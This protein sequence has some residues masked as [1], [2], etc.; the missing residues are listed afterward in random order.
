MTT[1]PCICYF[2]AGVSVFGKKSVII[3]V[4]STIMHCE[5]HRRCEGGSE[6]LEDTE[7]TV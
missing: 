1:T 7:D 5:Q 3:F 4:V 2:V 6:P